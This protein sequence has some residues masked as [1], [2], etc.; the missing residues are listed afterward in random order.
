MTINPLE[1]LADAIMAFEGWHVTSVSYRNRN[2][3]NLRDSNLKTGV[4]AKGY[5]IFGSLPQGYQALLYDLS[6]KVR[7]R[8]SHRLTPDS[9][10]Q[11]LFDVY[12]PRADRNNPGAYALFVCAWLEKALGREFTPETKLHEL[13]GAAPAPAA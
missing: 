5:A 11:S 6:A 3:G 4:D 9:T 13:E 8:S 2:P 7:G 10:L 12:A 1:A